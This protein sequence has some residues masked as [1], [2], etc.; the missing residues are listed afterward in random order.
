MA[1]I[2]GASHAHGKPLPARKPDGHFLDGGA[3]FWGPPAFE[4]G[5][6]AGLR[7][8]KNQVIALGPLR[9]WRL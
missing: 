1:F 7:W 9:L 8:L 2:L 3:A 6:D 4:G 5:G